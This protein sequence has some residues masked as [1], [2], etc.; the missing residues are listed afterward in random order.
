MES[1]LSTDRPSEST[2]YAWSL[3]GY[4]PDTSEFVAA[5]RQIAKPAFTQH[6]PVE[7]ERRWVALYCTDDDVSLRDVMGALDV[8]RETMHAMFTHHCV[9][10]RARNFVEGGV[11]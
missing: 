10:Y 11:R 1:L 3:Q 5:L 7:R 6:N 2:S 4:R 8:R 9:D